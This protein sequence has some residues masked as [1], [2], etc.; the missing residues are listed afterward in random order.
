MRADD[1]TLS[2][3]AELS[4]RG[5]KAAYRQFLVVCTAWLRPFYA[6]R[7]APCEIDDL[8]QET[9]LAVHN[10]LATY[11]VQRPFLPWLAAIAR[12]RWVDRLRQVYRAREEMLP[13]LASDVVEQDVVAAR[14]SIDALFRL[15]PA[16]QASAIRLVKI[17][18]LSIAEAS[19]QL[20]QSQASV[21]VNVHRGLRKM[22]SLIEA[23]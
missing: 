6:R 22:A 9:L 15:V 21:K 23:G 14:L 20:G 1:K 12:Y 2:C 10:K 4:Q 13:E 8:V 5:D 3:L 16:A 18:G 7:I 11:D 19:V 17:E